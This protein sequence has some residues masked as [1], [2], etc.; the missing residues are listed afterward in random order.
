MPHLTGS[1]A[2]QNVAPT[3]IRQMSMTVPTITGNDTTADVW[4]I[5]VA[6]SNGIQNIVGTA[7]GMPNTAATMRAIQA[8]VDAQV[9]H[10]INQSMTS[11]TSN[12]IW[13]V[14]TETYGT[15]AVV[16]PRIV[17]Q[18]ATNTQVWGAWNNTYAAGTITIGA[19][20]PPARQLTEAER[21][22]ARVARAAEDERWRAR[23]AAV[24]AEEAKAKDRAEKLLQE[25]LDGKQR[26]ELAAKGY[27]EL[28]V[29]SNNGSSRRYRIHR[30][31]SHS[32]QQI[33]PS[34]GKRLKTLCI[35]P[36]MQVPIA[37]SMLAQK[38]ML[39]SGMEEELL[40]I[41]NHS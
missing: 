41:A 24:Q 29:I 12:Q 23:N 36:G 5:W 15:T 32:I 7:I 22:A 35:H 9:H 18:T 2:A 4:P 34:S 25:S 20:L 17:N 10:A 31:W 14:W 37:D 3:I 38:L 26:A 6:D 11:G 8:A 39:E 21:E 30:Q 40:R 33:D 27:F 19:A 1:G 13:T 16:T 28:D